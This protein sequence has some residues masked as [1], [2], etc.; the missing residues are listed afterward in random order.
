MR[1]EA[2]YRDSGQKCRCEEVRGGIQARTNYRGG[3]RLSGSEPE[4]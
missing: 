2:R 4:T 1:V 3:V